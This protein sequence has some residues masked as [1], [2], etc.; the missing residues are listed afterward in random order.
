MNLKEINFFPGLVLLLNEQADIIQ[1]NEIASEFFVSGGEEFKFR[2]FS[3]FIDPE[4][5]ESFNS[6]LMKSKNSISSAASFELKIK[7]KGSKY[8]YMMASI[9]EIVDV[10][11]NEKAFFLSLVDLTNQKMQAHLIQESQKRFE[12]IANSAPVMIWITDSDGLFSFVNKVWCEFTGHDAGH[13]LGLN[14]LKNVHPEDINNLIER[15]QKAIVERS[16]ITV[17]FRFKNANSEFR[18][19]VLSGIPRYT[20]ENKYLGLI[21]TCTDISDQKDNE[22]KI[23][24][25]NTELNEANATKDKFFS[26]I[27]HDLRSPISGIMSLLEMVNEDFDQMGVDEIKEAIYEA[28]ISSRST[29]NLTEN[30]LEWSRVQTGRMSYSPKFISIIEIL[31]E[32]RSIYSQKFKEKNIT[33]EYRK[34]REISSYADRQMTQTILRNLISNA[35]KFSNQNGTIDVSIDVEVRF[36]TISVKDS[37]IGMTQEQI[38]KLFKIDVSQSTKGTAGESGTGLGLILCKELVEK[39]GGKIWVKSEVNQGTEFLFTLPRS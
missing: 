9:K 1:M 36:I 33:F 31:N 4:Y 39:Q 34:D 30:L 27:A 10:E 32:L 2:K 5:A 12:N 20:Q 26:I 6:A 19:L 37:G 25:I 3:E 7:G 23:K 29:F 13:E 16:E 11:S 21:G 8:F 28:S 17:E 14:W 38:D 35:I 15:Y 18:W 24:K 22:E